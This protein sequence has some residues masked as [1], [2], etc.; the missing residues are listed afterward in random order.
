[1]PLPTTDPADDF[2]DQ[3]QAWLKRLVDRPVGSMP[4]ETNAPDNPVPLLAAL[5]EQALLAGQN[6]ILL[7][8]DDQLLPELSNALDLA[9]RPLCLVLPEADFTARITLRASLSLLKSR[10]NREP[11]AGWQTV[12]AKQKDRM[13]D[14]AELWQAAQ[15]WSAAERANAWPEQ[16]GKLFPVR[17]APVGRALQ[18]EQPAEA[19][20]EQEADLLIVLEREPLPAAADALLA[21]CRVLI[22]NPP[23]VREAFL[24]ALALSDKELLLRGQVEAITRDIAELELELATARGE[25]SEFTHRYHQI[26]GMRITSLDALQA[27]LALYMAAKAPDDPVAKENAQE[28]KARA[29]QS[30]QDDRRYR[31]AAEEAGEKTQ[32]R[33]SADLKKLFRQVAQKIHPD[34][35][36][37]EN[38]RNWRTKLMAEANRAYRSGDVSTLREV[39]NLWQEGHPA[40]ALLRPDHSLLEQQLERLRARLS[41]IQRELDSLYGSRLYELFQAE[42]LARKQDR[43]LLEELAEQLDAQI[44]RTQQKL[45]DLGWDGKESDLL[46]EA[47]DGPASLSSH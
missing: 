31:E 30:H 32:F 23:P 44:L 22:L 19:R 37:D 33:P 29:E 45:R 11:D 36:R 43:D 12:W 38:D 9:V 24:G 7:V 28:A 14:Q 25:L 1:M 47:A 6:L 41:E 39:L 16:T 8:A 42:R 20:P 34:R 15:T 3:A 40:E 4:L 5:C 13:G 2:P 18:L 27:E 35:A 26:V 17:I 46:G 21:T 10:L